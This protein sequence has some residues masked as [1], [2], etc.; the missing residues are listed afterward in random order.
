MAEAAKVTRDLGDND[1]RER[2]SLTSIESAV[3]EQNM[4]NLGIA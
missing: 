3:V 4:A 2:F 1:V